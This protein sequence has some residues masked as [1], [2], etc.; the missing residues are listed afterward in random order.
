MLDSDQALGNFAA[1][2]FTFL[3][4]LIIAFKMQLVGILSFAVLFE[5]SLL[6]YVTALPP[7]G[8]RSIVMSVSVCP[9]GYHWSH[10]SKHYQCNDARGTG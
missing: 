8:L 2:C 1:I 10:R 5:L 6:L 3:C 7:V 4:L 9:N